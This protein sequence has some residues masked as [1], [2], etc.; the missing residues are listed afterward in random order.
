[1]DNAIEAME[2]APGVIAYQLPCHLK[3]QN[4]GTK[5]ADVMR[6]TGARVET[7]ERC[8]AMDGTWG[9]KKEYFELSM[10]LAQPLFKDI[11]AAQPDR[12]ATDCPLA[13]LQINQGTGR[14]AQH[15]IRL[16]ADAY[17]LPVE[18]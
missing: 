7:I 3:A 10:K 4:L 8:S 11:E 6:L 14:Q 17:G 5:S 13:A 12:V 15:P 16:L 18:D 1:V 9:M 2:N